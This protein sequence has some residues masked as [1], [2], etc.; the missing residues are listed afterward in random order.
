MPREIGRTLRIAIVTAMVLLLGLPVLTTGAATD[1][2]PGAPSV[3]SSLSA[4]FASIK[5]APDPAAVEIIQVDNGIAA[6]VLAGPLTGSDGLLWYQIEVSGITGYIAE[7][8]LAWGTFEEPVIEPEAPPAL[9][10]VT[11][12]GIVLSADGTDIACHIAPDVGA[13][14]LFSYTSGSLVDL[15]GTPSN[16]WQPVIC[17]TQL[18]YLPAELVHDPAS[19]V[20]PE[21][22]EAPAQTPEAT[23]TE[24]AFEPSETPAPTEITPTE[25]ETAPE[26][27]E[28]PDAGDPSATAETEPS[29]DVPASTETPETEATVD[30]T[31]TA[32][33]ATPDATDQVPADDTVG[34]SVPESSPQATTESVGQTVGADDDQVVSA[35]IAGSAVVFNTGA[36]G[37]RCRSEASL[38]SPVLVVLPLGASVELTSAA[39]SGWQ[40]VVCD[41]QNGFVAARFLMASDEIPV[42][43]PAIEPAAALTGSSGVVQNTDGDG[44]RCRA[45]ASFTGAVITVLPEG[46]QV[47]SRGA[48]VGVWQPVTCAGQPGWVHMDFIGNASGSGGSSGGGSSAS[49]SATVTGTNGDGVRFRAGAGYDAAVIAVLMEGTTVNLRNGTVGSWTAISYGGRDGFVYADFLTTARNPSPGGGS[50]VGS[51]SLAPGSNAKVTDLL[52]FRSGASYS[53]SVIAIASVGTVVRVTGSISG[54]FYPVQWGGVSGYMHGDY[55]QY[56][57]DGLSSGGP[58]SGVGGGGSGAGSGAGS[59]SGQ[60]MVSYAMRYLGYPYIWATHGPSSFDCSGFT[61]WVVLNVLGIDI[62]AGTWTQWGTGAPIQYGNLQPGDLVFFQNTYT[63][64]L[65]HVGMYIGNDQFIHAENEDTGVRISSLSSQYYSTR[66]L[67]ARRLS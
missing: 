11:G 9:P 60:A 1:L 30:A 62:G 42:E 3:I 46:T 55:L 17:A 34:Q 4:P 51:S 27:T 64:G 6:T 59:A 47:A 49:G 50:G 35:S 40:P 21:P 37:L 43:D 26:A 24:V 31:E 10:V 29:T 44:L 28:S 14:A 13:E 63:V 22:T 67:G 66:Y 15:A 38:T 54:G 61:Y 58:N 18:G 8:D 53:A 36:G 19:L 23:E 45:Q 7:P 2:T 32:V 41:G 16:G 20:T 39:S 48:A 33:T 5:S 57:T 25:T 65:S 56:T 12:N 52:N